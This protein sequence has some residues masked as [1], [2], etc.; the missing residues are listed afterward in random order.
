MLK[1]VYA[2]ETITVTRLAKPL[3]K[4]VAQRAVLAVRLGQ[5]LH[6]Q[7][8]VATLLLPAGLVGVAALGKKLPICLVDEEAVE[9]TLGGTWLSGE[10]EGQDG[11]FLAVLPTTIE[12]LIVTLWQTA[13]LLASATL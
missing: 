5:A 8:G 4:V 9:L 7:K 12:S 13:R 10:A 3:E 6:I 2:A 11:V 1:I